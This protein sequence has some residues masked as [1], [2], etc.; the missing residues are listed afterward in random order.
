M[1]VSWFF[2]E[3]NATNTFSNNFLFCYFCK[4]DIFIQPVHH[5]LLN[6]SDIVFDSQTEAQNIY[7][8][9]TPRSK[10]V[11]ALFLNLFVTAF[12]FKLV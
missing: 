1:V 5:F 8:S 9:F 7:D 6:S 10:H 12:L 11:L 4:P 3:Y 2:T